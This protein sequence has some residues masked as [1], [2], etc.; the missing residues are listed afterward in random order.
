MLQQPELQP[1]GSV[2]LEHTFTLASDPYLTDHRLDQKPVLPAAGALEWMAELVQ[3]AWPDWIVTEI[4][5]LRVMRGLVLEQNE[6]KSVL[7]KARSST[8]ADSSTLAVTIEIID[9][10]KK[11]PYYRAA[12]ILHS[13]I[14]DSPRLEAVSIISGQSLDPK[15]AY[16]NYLFHGQ[17][18][19]LI[20]AIEQ[21]SEQGIDAQVIPTNPLK[22]LN[23]SQSTHSQWLF[24]PGLIDTAPQ[25]AIVWARV[26]GD[27]TALPSRFGSVIRYSASQQSQPLHIAFRVKEFDG[28]SLNYDAIF[29]DSNGRV[30]FHLQDISGTCNAALNRLA[31]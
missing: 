24:D 13:Q 20:T 1:N 18:F 30:H 6:S 9:P 4:R 17:Y 16:Q 21:I 7:F 27:T 15:I 5:D 12:V 29:F 11:L 23:R 8:H 10:E 19:Q 31:R 14:P 26:N 28:N 25:L 3:Q 22:W 2:I